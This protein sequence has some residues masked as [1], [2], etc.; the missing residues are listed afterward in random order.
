MG[1]WIQ[2]SGGF[3]SFGMAINAG[4]VFMV[5]V[6]VVTGGLVYLVARRLTG[7]PWTG[8]LAIALFSFSSLSLYYQREALIDNICTF[9]LMLA[10]Y[11]LTS[12]ASRLHSIVSAAIVFGVACLTKETMIVL[13]P[14][15]AYGVWCEIPPF[16]RRFAIV[17]FTYTCVGLL[18][19]FVLLAVLKGELFP[20]QPRAGFLYKIFLGGS[21][22]HVSLITTFLSQAGRGSNGGSFAQQ[23]QIWWHDDAAFLLAGS[24]SLVVVILISR[25]RSNIRVVPLMALLYALFLARGGVTLEYYI[26]PLIPLIALNITLAVDGVVRAGGVAIALITHRSAD[27]VRSRLAPLLLM[28]LMVLLFVRDMR[29]DQL[30]LN[31]NATAP[32]VAALEWVGTHVPRSAVIVANPYEWLDMRASGGLAAGYGA[33]FGQAQAYWEVA[34]D[35]AVY[36]TILHNDWNNIDYVLLDPDMLADGGRFGMGLVPQALKHATVVKTFTNTFFYVTIYQVQ[37]RF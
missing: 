4:R 16:Q 23:W 35:P 25:R 29:L 17:A 7:N 28:P 1:L 12:A 30:E 37:H 33:P 5:V 8:L 32:E 34:T 20:Y 2:L 10:L 27:T 14:A 31:S 11:L 22:P 6:N 19:A 26:L 24:I 36:S 9:W 21:H 3:F 13:L 15:F 18:S